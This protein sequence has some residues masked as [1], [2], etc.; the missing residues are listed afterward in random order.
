[1]A[2]P[3]P[4]PAPVTTATAPSRLPTT[5]PPSHVSGRHIHPSDSSL[6]FLRDVNAARFSIDNLRVFPTPQIT[7]GTGYVYAPYW[8][9]LFVQ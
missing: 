4:L 7:P 2:R 3:I 8:T 5:D 6:P 1:M 9:N